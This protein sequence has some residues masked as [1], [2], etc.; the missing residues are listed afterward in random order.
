MI[1][2]IATL[3]FT[4]TATEHNN[5]AKK[6]LDRRYYKGC[7]EHSTKAI[8]ADPTNAKYYWVR[9]KGLANDKQFDAALSDVNKVMKMTTPTAK[10]Y[11]RKGGICYYKAEEL[12]KKAK[13]Y[14]PESSEDNLSDTPD[15][16]KSKFLKEAQEYYKQAL[17]T[18]DK[19]IALSPDYKNKL[20]RQISMA[21][22]RITQ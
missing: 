21:N 7:I 5:N 3:G 17:T 2:F 12:T 19:A 18:Y 13:L 9:S 11:G 15:N 4:Q 10:M 14:R 22:S 20:S 6:D 8:E 1:A 16:I